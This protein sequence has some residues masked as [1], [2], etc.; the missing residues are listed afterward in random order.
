MRN[1]IAKSVLIA[2]TALIATQIPVGGAEHFSPVFNNIAKADDQQQITGNVKWYIATDKIENMKDVVNS[3]DCGHYGDEADLGIKASFN[4]PGNQIKKGNQLVLTTFTQTSTVHPNATWDQL[5]SMEY[6]KVPDNP[7]DTSVTVYD[8]NNHRIGYIYIK[9]QNKLMLNVDPEQKYA[10]DSIVKVNFE[11]SYFMRVNQ[12]PNVNAFKGN[13]SNTVTFSVR[14]SIDNSSVNINY[15]LANYKEYHWNTNM[16]AVYN[17]ATIPFWGQIFP[18]LKQDETYVDPTKPITN[19]QNF[20]GV[21]QIVSPNI[22]KNTH[23]FSLSSGKLSIL[24]KDGNL[25]EENDWV[26]DRDWNSSIPVKNA[27]DDKNPEQMN[28]LISKSENENILWYSYLSDGQALVAI[29]AN[30]NSDI[31]KLDKQAVDDTVKAS[32]IYQIQDPEHQ[33]EILKKNEDFY[34]QNGGHGTIFNFNFALD[35]DP[36]PNSGQTIG[37]DVTPGVT[38]FTNKTSQFW[39]EP[40]GANGEGQLEKHYTAEFIDDTT[41]M[42]VGSPT[43]KSGKAGDTGSLSLK[44]PDGYQLVPGQTVP[45][46]Y[47]ILDH[48]QVV[49]IHLTHAPKPVNAAATATRTIHYVIGADGTGGKAFDDKSQDVKF[50]GTVD[51]VTGNPISLKPNG[52][53]DQVVS[54][55]LKG[56]TPDIKVVNA[57]TP[58]PNQRKE[59]TVHYLANDE[60]AKLRVIDDHT[61]LELQGYDQEA[62]GKFNTAISFDKSPNDVAKELENKGYKIVSNSWQ[63]GSKYQDGKNEFA[64]HVDH[65]TSTQTENHAQT[66][67]IH[68]VDGKGNKMGDDVVQKAS[69]TRTGT[70]DNVTGKIDWK[71]WT[72]NDKYPEVSSPV[73]EGYTADRAKVDAVTPF[74]GQNQDQTVVYHRNGQGAEITYVDD[75]TG[76]V[77]KHEQ[78][79]G[80]Y[81]DKIVFNSNVPDT[82]KGYENDG[83]VLVSNDFKDQSYSSDNVANKFTVHFKHGTKQVTRE[84]SVSQDIDYQIKENGTTHSVNHYKAPDLKFTQSGIQDNVTKEINWNGTVKD[85][86]FKAFNTP[87]I[88]GYTPDIKQVPTTNIHVDSKNWNQD[89]S[90]KKT[91]TYT[92]DQE[93]VKVIAKDRDTNKILNQSQ[94]TG[95]YGSEYH[96]TAP[97]INGYHLVK[98]PANVSGKFGTDNADVVYLYAKDTPTDQGETTG[99]PKADDTSVFN[100]N[101]A[102]QDTKDLPEM[103]E[104]NMATA[105]LAGLGLLTLTGLLPVIKR[106]IRN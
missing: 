35:W 19:P 92:P 83:Y 25:T 71:D 45:N 14:S 84:K 21:M 34:L 90:I 47:T 97:K 18:F 22:T 74:Y 23:W 75:T 100:Q 62:N 40:A 82:I 1:K 48:D 31:F 16:H 67:T 81:N 94:L 56:Y 37:T 103:S 8:Q 36:M 9:D 33:A 49:Q 88:K 59:V 72:T 50:S 66:R 39:W 89:Q 43:S 79:Q 38:Q 86:Q 99:T 63:D 5:L 68:Y 27:G 24:N 4:I 93:T 3:I 96:A 77:L 53:W 20:K 104:A 51:S 95:T 91:V 32:Y 87:T 78:A 54:P 10:D 106:K 17:N 80:K 73:H 44:V 2:G 29:N 42:I 30:P 7:A 70:K 41:G 64:I 60:K 69:F 28:E 61:G 26:A 101:L 98:T 13:T 6:N 102:K 12:H 55:D 85:Q 52:Q 46:S 105:T 11:N 15:N 58:N 65:T 76:K 57:E